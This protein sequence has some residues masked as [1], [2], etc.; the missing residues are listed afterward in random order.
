[1]LD[2]YQLF[3]K[4][5]GVFMFKYHKSLLPRSFDDMFINMKTIH[6]YNTGG[7]DNYRADIHKWTNVLTRGPRLWNSLPKEIKAAKHISEFKKGI[8]KYLKDGY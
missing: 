8:V 5:L 3:N 1:M 4:D 7:R 6:N 2:V